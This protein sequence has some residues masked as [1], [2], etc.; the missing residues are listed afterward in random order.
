MDRSVVNNLLDLSLI[1]YYYSIQ[2]EINYVVY[3]LH[4]LLPS[5]VDQSFD[6]IANLDY[7]TRR[8]IQASKLNVG[9]DHV[10]PSKKELFCSYA[11]V[12]K[13]NLNIL[14]ESLVNFSKYT[15]D[16]WRNE[17]E[18]HRM[19]K[20][21]YKKILQSTIHRMEIFSVAVNA[22]YTTDCTNIQ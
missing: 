7:G 16:L 20:I 1:R 9:F 5:T 19:K 2:C 11:H 22:Q 10:F 18:R 3:I 15:E 4:E 12:I 14:V 6:V 17:P 13:M 21:E 8:I